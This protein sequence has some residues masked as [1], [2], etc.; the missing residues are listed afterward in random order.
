MMITLIIEIKNLVENYLHQVYNVQFDQP[1]Y[2]TTKSLVL[3]NFLIKFL[4]ALE[5]FIGILFSL[6][7]F[8]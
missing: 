3:V 4:K 6:K 1:Q 2:W 5:K 8:E 7:S